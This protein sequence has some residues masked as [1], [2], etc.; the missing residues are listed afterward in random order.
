MTDDIIVAIGTPIGK[1]GIAV[2]RLSGKGCLDLC[3]KMFHALKKDAKVEPNLMV[4]GDI[5]L[6]NTT[7]KGFMVYFK[8]PRSYTGED[9]V[10]FQCHGGYI[11][12]QKI[13]EKAISLGARLAQP[14]EFS[15]RAFLNGKMSLDQAEGVIDSINA[16][17][18]SEL[19]ASSLL[20][21]GSLLEKVKSF[22][23][24]LIDMMSEIEVNL[25]YPEHDIEYETK[26]KLK[27]RLQHILNEIESLLSSQKKGKIIKNGIDISI[28]GKPNVGKSM[29]LNALIGSQQAIVTDVEG[30]TRDVVVGSIEYKGIKF[31]FLDTAGLRH[32]TDK[33][34]SI[35]IEKTKQVLSQSDLI[36]FVLDSSKKFDDRDKEILDYVKDKKV[37]F[38]LNKIDLPRDISFDKDNIEVSA[39]DGINI[40]N[41]KEKIYSNAI[42]G[43]QTN[44]NIILTNIRHIDV[45]NSAKGMAENIICSLLDLSL[46]LISLDVRLLYEKLGEITGETATEEVINRIFSKF[47]LGK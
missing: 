31:N 7:D 3:Q 4:L 18:E 44:S 26:E 35:G 17:T 12:A 37:L 2:V 45:L 8:S 30:T 32:T 39:K 25:D 10:E 11:I 33:V 14:G 5:Q 21:R 22:Q 46:D 47:C 9:V 29:L 38:V 15:K 34:E 40:E 13:V 20:A 19:K 28:I 41:L 23:D 36:L 42:D 27:T 43:T 24:Q 16:E 6:N 1:A